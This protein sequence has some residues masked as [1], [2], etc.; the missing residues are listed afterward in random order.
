[1]LRQSGSEPSGA[2]RPSRVGSQLVVC[3]RGLG[4]EPG[5]N[6]LLA[7]KQ[8]AQSVTDDL[9][10]AG[11]GASGHAFLQRISHLRWQGDAELLRRSH[12]GASLSIG[13]NPTPFGLP[14]L[15]GAGWCGDHDHTRGAHHVRS[16]GSSSL[17][18]PRHITASL[19]RA[20][21]AA[22]Y[23]NDRS[24]S[25]AS[26]WSCSGSSSSREANSPE[27]ALIP[28]SSTWVNSMPLDRCIVITTTFPGE[29]SASLPTNFASI[30]RSVRARC[31]VSA[32]PF[33]CTRTPMVSAE[34]TS[35]S[36]SW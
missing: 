6:G 2:E 24:C 7:G 19:S 20:R 1:G 14:T 23:S 29:T 4:A 25:S 16:A 13:F 31:T 36:H 21:V 18:S 5:L 12:E 32:T 10:L 34:S 3:G 9:A 30:P 8:R 35:F 22:T 33:A 26:A 27:P 17:R 15:S 11:I 28:K